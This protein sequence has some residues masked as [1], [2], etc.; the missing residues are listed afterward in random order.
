MSNGST[1]DS[2]TLHLAYIETVRRHLVGPS[3]FASSY[4]SSIATTLR[5]RWDW[6]GWALPTS[7]VVA[8]HDDGV[9]SNPTH[10]VSFCVAPGNVMTRSISE[11][12]HS[13]R[14]WA[15]SEQLASC[16]SANALVNR[17][18]YTL[19]SQCLSVVTLER[20]HGKAA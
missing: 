19:R 2:T 10:G 4:S 7:H 3:C 5:A 20:N 6:A 17:G 12:Q 18:G 11:S 16:Q 8:H 14:G 13:K 15:A 9:G 1:N